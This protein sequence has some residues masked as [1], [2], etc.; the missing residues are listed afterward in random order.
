LTT[1]SEG[2]TQYENGPNSKSLSRISAEQIEYYLDA[3]GV[4]ALNK[5]AQSSIYIN[6]Y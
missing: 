1:Q 4:A 5:F 2:K 6:L 3:M